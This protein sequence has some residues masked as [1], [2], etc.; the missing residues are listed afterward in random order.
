MLLCAVMAVAVA[1]AGMTPLKAWRHDADPSGVVAVTNAV[2]RAAEGAFRIMSY[3]IR[4][5]KG[6]DDV[7]DYRRSAARILSESPDFVCVQEIW[8]KKQFDELAGYL[9][10]HGAFANSGGFLGNAVFSRER[11]LKCEAVELPYSGKWKRTLVLC[12]YRDFVVGSM[13]LDLDA[14]KRHESVEVV[15]EAIAKYTK[16]VFVAGDWNNWPNTPVLKGLKAFLQVI[17]PQKNVHTWHVRTM[18]R[19]EC[20]IDY[21]AVDKAHAG[22]FSVLRS[23]EIPDRFTSDHSPIAVDVMPL[24]PSPQPANPH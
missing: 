23:Y 19:R 8:N 14:K 15:R 13:H 17:S 9:G 21:I 4:F 11:P 5:G 24:P 1:G 20:I 16:P 6:M 7:R 12:E 2:S 10:M 18:K 22:N 3:N